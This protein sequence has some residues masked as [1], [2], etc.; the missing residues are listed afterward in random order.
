MKLKN[1][2]LVLLFFTAMSLSYSQMLKEAT[3]EYLPGV[4]LKP[5]I[6]RSERSTFKRGEYQVEYVAKKGFKFKSVSIDV[7][8]TTDKDVVLDFESFFLVDEQGNRYEPTN[9]LQSGKLTNKN[10]K[11]QMTLKAGK[12]KRYSV[13]FWPA[14]PVE[15]KT[16]RLD[17]DGD[18]IDL[19]PKEK[20]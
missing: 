11:F 14:V 5:L 16:F 9:I 8:N 18:V 19:E 4:T 17:V 3:H 15:L 1:M 12:T 6:I 2:L 10:D 7:S 13:G 20:D